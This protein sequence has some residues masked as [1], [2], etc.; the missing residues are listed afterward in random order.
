MCDFKKYAEKAKEKQGLRSDR[1]LAKKIGITQASI[2]K[3][4][5]GETIPKDETMIKVAELAGVPMEQALVDLQIWRAEKMKNSKVKS[6]WKNLHKMVASV[7]L[8]LAFIIA[9]PSS[10]KSAEKSL[11]PITVNI[12]YATMLCSPPCFYDG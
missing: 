7:A 6:F 8:V 4:V 2:Q 5:I 1:A 12:N 9:L 10:S 3:L 11:N